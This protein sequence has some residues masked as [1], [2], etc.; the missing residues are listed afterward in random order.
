[1]R[2][3]PYLCRRTIGMVAMPLLLARGMAIVCG[4]F[5]LSCLIADGHG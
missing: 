2:D 4:L 1:M 5:N 3:A